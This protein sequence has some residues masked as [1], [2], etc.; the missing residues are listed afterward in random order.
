MGPYDLCVITRDVEHL[1]RT[2][3]DV[4]RAALEGGATMIQL[5]EKD[6]SGD[7]LL[8][9][10]LEL[11]SLARARG[12][13]FIVNDRVDIALA[14]QADGVHLGEHDLPVAVAR[15]LLGPDAIIGASVN[16]PR[17]AKEAQDAGASYLGVGP[18]FPTL[19]KADAG[20]AIGLAPLTDI[21]R[22][23]SLP[24]LAIGGLACDNIAR[25]IQAGADGIAVIS[26]VV[27]APDMAAAAAALLRCVRQARQ[28]QEQSA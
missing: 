27:E 2:H 4:A 12:A 20:E 23:A 18:I 24:M 21:T 9:L 26:A 15:R 13:T 7:E 16:N 3:L 28:A 22:I 10:A 1:N 6:L 25:V 5:R 11:R 8:R 19:S 14:S 17:R